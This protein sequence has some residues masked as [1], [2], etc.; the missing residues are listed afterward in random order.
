MTII[1]HFFRAPT[2]ANLRH[3]KFGPQALAYR[4]NQVLNSL[5]GVDQFGFVPG[6]DIR[7]ALCYF[8]DLMNHCRRNNASGPIGAICLDF[9]KDFD[10]VNWQALDLLQFSSL[11]YDFFRGI[12]VQDLANSSRSDSFKLGA[13]VRQADPLSPG[14]FVLFIEPFICYLRATNDGM[15]IKIHDTSHHL[16]SFADNGSGLVNDLTHAPRFL[17][18]VNDFCTATVMRLNVDKTV[19]FPFLG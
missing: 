8:Y 15:A 2:A 14:L 13:G 17:A 3:A 12:L 19:L 9:A 1:K 4:L 6:Q 7:H 18:R 11:H 10:S 5:L 16:L